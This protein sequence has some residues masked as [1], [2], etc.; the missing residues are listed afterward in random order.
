MPTIG[1]YLFRTAKDNTSDLNCS[2][3]KALRS[4]A[5]CPSILLSMALQPL[6]GLG[7]PRKTPPFTSISSSS[8][9]SSYAQHLQCIPLNYI[10]PFS[11]WS[12][13]WSCGMEVPVYN[14]FL[15]FFLLP[16]LLY[17]PNII[18]F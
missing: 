7:H 9:P 14:C 1:G 15:E 2:D 17:D 10:R 3:T 18:V 8:P 13:H 6:P 12:S 16:S 4:T 11:S 5:V